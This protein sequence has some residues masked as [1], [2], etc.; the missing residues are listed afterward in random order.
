MFSF[1]P[2]STVIS[3]DDN[4]RT[5]LFSISLL[6]KSLYQFKEKYA[7]SLTIK[8]N[9]TGRP[10]MISFLYPEKIILKQFLNIYF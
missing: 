2:I 4:I 3:K 5:S 1:E 7:V 10:T 9:K 8:Y 6:L